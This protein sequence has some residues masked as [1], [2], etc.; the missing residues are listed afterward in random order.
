M[1]MYNHAK[2]LEFYAKNEHDLTYALQEL[3]T[4]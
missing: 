3:L 2:N 4:H 1:R